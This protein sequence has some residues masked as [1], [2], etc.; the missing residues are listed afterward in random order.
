MMGARRSG[1]SGHPGLSDFAL[2]GRLALEHVVAASG[3]GSL[4]QAV[5]SLVLFSHP[6]TVKP[7]AEQ[8]HLPYRPRD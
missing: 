4:T 6:S 3:Y 7:S 1:C 5:A 8:G 2:D